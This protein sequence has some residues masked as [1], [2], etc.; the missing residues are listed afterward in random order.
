MMRI[1]RRLTHRRLPAGQVAFEFKPKWLAP[2]P[3][4]PPSAVR[5]RNC[6][7]EA[8]KVIHRPLA[9]ARPHAH[10]D[11]RRPPRPPFC[12]LD[13]VKCRGDD[14]ALD[15][16]L[17][18]LLACVVGTTDTQRAAFRV[19]LRANHLVPLLYDLQARMDGKRTHEAA[20][21]GGAFRTSNGAPDLAAESSASENN[22]SEAQR[23]GNLALA[24]T[25]RDCSCFV[26]ISAAGQVEAKLADLDMKNSDAKA[27]KWEEQETRLV[28]EGYYSAQENPQQATNCLLERYMA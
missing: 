7:Q 23:T 16:A 1:R 5:C 6:A 17:D 27:M 22:R 9:D 20:G 3:R 21:V 12:P 24:M 19:W 13:L 4:A 26:R 25:L 15:A 28:A 18:A 8:W 11:D 10:P 2:S 14:A